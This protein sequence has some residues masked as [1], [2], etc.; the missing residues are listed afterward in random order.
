METIRVNRCVHCMAD[1]KDLKGNFCNRCG[2]PAQQVDQP[3]YCLRPFSI[4]RGKYLVGPMLGQGELWHHLCGAGPE[5]GVQSGDQ[6]V[7][8][9][10]YGDPQ[11]QRVQP[12]GVEHRY[13]SG[14][15][16]AQQ[17]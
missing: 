8:S 1:L 17:L 5:P 14:Q 6:R 9:R 7:L 4:L 2:K 10:F 11:L 12:T 16:V 3:A 15:P 13:E